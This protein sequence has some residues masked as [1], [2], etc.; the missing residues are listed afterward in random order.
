MAKLVTKF[1]YY[2]P[3]A[4]TSMGG[5]MKYIATRDGVE[6]CDDSKQFAPATVKQKELIEKILKDYP[7]SRTML[8]YEDYLAKPTQKNATGD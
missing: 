6:K 4:S 8:E 1:R 2:K 5:Y 3:S 7:D